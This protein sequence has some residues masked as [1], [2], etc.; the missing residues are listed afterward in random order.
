MRVHIAEGLMIR[1]E[2]KRLR[3]EVVLPISEGLNHRIE[4][5]IISEVALLGFV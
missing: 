1:I 2:D 3:E 4:F 5:L